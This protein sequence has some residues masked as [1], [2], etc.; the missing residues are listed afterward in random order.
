MLALTQGLIMDP[1]GRMTAAMSSSRAATT[2]MGTGLGMVVDLMGDPTAAAEVT[3][4]EEEAA[5]NR[6]HARRLQFLSL[7]YPAVPT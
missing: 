2:S 6:R 1:T 7:F 3:A 5:V 4:V